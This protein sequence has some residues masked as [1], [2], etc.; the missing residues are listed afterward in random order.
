[1]ENVRQVFDVALREAKVPADKAK[2]K[3]SKA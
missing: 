2:A 1:V 3:A